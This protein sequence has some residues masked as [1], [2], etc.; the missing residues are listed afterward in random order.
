MR[1]NSSNSMRVVDLNIYRHMGDSLEND[2]D[3]H[4]NLEFHD[5]LL[6]LFQGRQEIRGINARIIFTTVILQPSHP[7]RHTH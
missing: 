7:P 1:F 3:H 5:E 4:R 2:L 6:G